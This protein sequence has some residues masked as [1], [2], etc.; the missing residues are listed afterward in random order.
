MSGLRQIPKAF[1]VGLVSS[2]HL[3]LRHIMPPLVILLLQLLLFDR[4]TLHL[5]IGH[6][7]SDPQTERMNTIQS[8]DIGVVQVQCPLPKLDIPDVW[9]LLEAPANFYNVSSGNS[10]R[11]CLTSIWRFAGS[12]VETSTQRAILLIF[13]S[14]AIWVVLDLMKKHKID[15]PFTSE[16]VDS[17]FVQLTE[18]RVIMLAKQ[19]VLHCKNSHLKRV[20]TCDVAFQVDTQTMY[21]RYSISRVDYIRIMESNRNCWPESTPEISSTL[22]TNPSEDG[23]TTTTTMRS[24]T[25]TV[26]NVPRAGYKTSLMMMIYFILIAGIMSACWITWMTIVNIDKPNNQIR[27]FRD[28][29]YP[30]ESVSRTNLWNKSNQPV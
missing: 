25:D 21:G 26:L 11:A 27:Q 7:C 3:W 5:A 17:S 6:H 10:T 1:V 4:V 12:T 13:R 30:L 20:V 2:L 23:G 8:T 29:K 16:S 24:T 9:T 19:K 18:D 15:R 22:P 28:T 14:K